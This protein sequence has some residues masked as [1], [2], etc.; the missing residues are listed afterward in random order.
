LVFE[1]GGGLGDVRG[2]SGVD[3]FALFRIHVNGAGSPMA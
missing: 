1:F 2:Q 3:V